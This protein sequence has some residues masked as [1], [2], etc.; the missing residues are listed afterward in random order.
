ME[1][2]GVKGLAGPN[3]RGR[4]KQ[5]SPIP[6]KFDNPLAFITNGPAAQWGCG[7]KKLGV[8]GKGQEL[9]NSTPENFASMASQVKFSFFMAIFIVLATVVAAHDGHHHM[10]PAQPPSSHASSSFSNHHAVIAGIFPLLLT[11]L[12]ARERP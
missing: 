1:E 4:D 2:P 11:L 3:R 10:A 7:K 6:N 9:K 12:I 8:V 5:Y